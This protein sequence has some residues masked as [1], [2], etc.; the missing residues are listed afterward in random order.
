MA[1][2]KKVGRPVGLPKSDGSGRKTYLTDELIESLSSLLRESNYLVTALAIHGIAESV[3]YYWLKRGREE[4]QNNEKYPDTDWNASVY[5]RF[6][7]NTTRASAEAEASDIKR[8]RE[9]CDGW[10]SLAWI[11]ERRSRKRWGRYEPSDSVASVNIDNR[12]VRVK[13]GDSGSGSGQFKEIITK[14]VEEPK[15]HQNGGE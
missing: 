1:A 7:L 4:V 15:Q 3:G 13:I 5:A 14:E 8:I 6:Y 10:Q 12:Q 2:S 11:R 9:G